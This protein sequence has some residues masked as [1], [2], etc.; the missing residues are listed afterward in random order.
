MLLKRKRPTI[1]SDEEKCQSIFSAVAFYM[2]HLGVKTRAVDSKK[3]RGGF[4]RRQL[5]KNKK[6]EPTKGKPRGVFPG[7]PSWIA[8]NTDAK[9]KTEAEAEKE[10]VNPERKSL[11]PGR[12]S[13]TEPAAPSIPSKKSSGGPTTAPG[14]EI[15]DGS[16]NNISTTNSPESSNMDGLS[17]NRLE[18]PVVSDGGDVSP[19]S[20]AGGLT[21]MEPLSPSDSLTEENLEKDRCLRLSWPGPVLCPACL[22][23][24]LRVVPGG[25]L[26]S[27][28]ACSTLLDSG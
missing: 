28:L 6:D 1:V 16:G 7:I 22:H 27:Y 17:N 24:V 26:S 8:G 10:K 9:P 14:L 21:V 19:V 25:L 2:K 11:A 4:F 23:S 13:L 5:V 3:S 18:P 20:L 15:T 12:G